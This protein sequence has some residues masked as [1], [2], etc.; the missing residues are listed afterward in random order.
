V[1]AYCYRVGTCIDRISADDGTIYIVK[2]LS[3]Q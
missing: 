3:Q 1:V 2:K